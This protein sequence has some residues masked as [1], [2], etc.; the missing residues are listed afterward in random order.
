M[1]GGVPV[2]QGWAELS[3]NLPCGTHGVTPRAQ[4]V[5]RGP[6][7][8]TQARVLSKQNHLRFGAFSFSVFFFDQWKICLNWHLYYGRNKPGRSEGRGCMNAV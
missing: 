8:Q 4:L 1:D 5:V 7:K 6:R 2:K 3:E